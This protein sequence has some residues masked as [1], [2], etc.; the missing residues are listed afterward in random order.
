[1]LG[2]V[3]DNDSDDDND[4]DDDEI[5]RHPKVGNIIIFHSAA[6]RGT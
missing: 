3:E 4:R 6:V 5:P 2:N 1:M